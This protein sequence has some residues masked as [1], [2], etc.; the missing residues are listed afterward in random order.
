[1]TYGDLG[2]DGHVSFGPFYRATLPAGTD[3][4]AGTGAYSL[5]QQDEN[6]AVLFVR[7]FDF[8]TQAAHQLPGQRPS[9]LPLPPRF[10]ETV[11]WDQA[12]R[13]IVCK[14]GNT[15]IAS[16]LVSPGT[17]SVTVI[18]PNGGESWAKDGTATVR[19]SASDADGDPLVYK[20][21]YSTDGGGNWRTL[22]TDL[23]ED[24]LLV[25]AAF[26]PGS[27]TALLRVSATDG[28]NT[29][30]D[31]S[32]AT[33]TVAR[34]DPAV[35]IGGV[36]DNAIVEAGT[37]LNLVANYVDPNEEGIL[38]DDF[39]WRAAGL[40]VLATGAHLE[41]PA[42]QLP[43][44]PHRITVTVPGRGGPPVSASVNILRAPRL[45]EL[46][47]ACSGDCDARRGHDRGARSQCSRRSEQP[48]RCQRS[49]LLTRI[50]TARLAS[51]SS[52][53]P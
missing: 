53:R 15:V 38:D 32:D 29:A 47:A 35:S 41:L 9:Q 22:T 12:T 43:P 52:S 33:F 50:W 7:H 19:W 45:R 39:V 3:D 24:T 42:T 46:L 21:E 14:H 17:P 28:V 37:L 40:G 11:P 18:S 20:V 4:D 1:M 23:S 25:N 13:Q 49:S 6:G 48:A 5:E 26:L 44:G 34:K 51:T 2:D 30:V 36:E 31:E 10:R 8:P 16:R 27:D